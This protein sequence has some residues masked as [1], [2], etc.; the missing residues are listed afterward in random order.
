MKS[1]ILV[2]LI[3]F[4]FFAKSANQWTD[5]KEIGMVY[6]YTVP[7]SLHVYLIGETC[8]NTKNYFS[9]TDAKQANAAQLVSMILVAKSSKKKVRVFY[10]PNESDTLCY[11]KGLQVEQ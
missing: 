7:N 2:I 5:W 10:N 9:I 11:F 6:T 4:S 8:P 1:I 3:T